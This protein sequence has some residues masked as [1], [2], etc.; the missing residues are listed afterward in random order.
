M[1]KNNTKRLKLAG[2]FG[3]V[4]LLQ[5]IAHAGYYLPESSTWQGSRYYNQN[6]VYA[7]VEYAVYNTDS[8]SYHDTMDGQIDGFA[9]PGNGQYIYAYQVINLGTDLNPI[10]TFSLLDGDPTAT[11]YIGYTDDGNGGL[12]PDNYGGSFIWEF[13]NGLFIANAHSAFLVFTSDS[14]PVAGSLNISTEYGLEPPIVPETA[15]ASIPEP[16]TITL[17]TVGAFALLKRKSRK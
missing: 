8:N 11:D 9:N 6:D 14:A 2:L 16:A 1:R 12:V 7:Y 3:A 15:A 5:T 10:A 13:T 4:L 17:F